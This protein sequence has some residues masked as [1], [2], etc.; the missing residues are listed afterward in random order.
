MTVLALRHSKCRIGPAMICRGRVRRN[1]PAVFWS[2]PAPSRGCA[3]ELSGVATMP[4]GSKANDQQKGRAA[5]ARPITLLAPGARFERAT[6]RLTADCSTAELPRISEGRP[7][8][9][10]PRGCKASSPRSAPSGPA[11]PSVG[12]PIL[13]RRPYHGITTHPGSAATRG[14]QLA[15]VWCIAA[16]PFLP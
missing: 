9:R 16:G 13:P 10:P 5:K 8:T 14:D 12:A 1:Q 7:Y 6:D 15:R 4:R 11:G 2:T 3:L